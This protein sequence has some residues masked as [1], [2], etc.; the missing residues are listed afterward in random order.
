MRQILQINHNME[1]SFVSS[2]LLQG[3]LKKAKKYDIE[4]L[5][6]YSE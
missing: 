1:R 4:I 3:Y 2:Y 5:I 6:G